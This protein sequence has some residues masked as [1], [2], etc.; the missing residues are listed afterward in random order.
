[1]ELPTDCLVIAL[2]LIG[3]GMPYA[4]LGRLWD[5]TELVLKLVLQTTGNTVLHSFGK[6][7]SLPPYTHTPIFSFV[8]W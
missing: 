8:K 2:Y 5:P 6:A 4:D 1:M 3:R 7:A